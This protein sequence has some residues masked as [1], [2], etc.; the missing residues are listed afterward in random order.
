MPLRLN[1]VEIKDLRVNGVTVDTMMLNGVVVYEGYRS[2]FDNFGTTWY[3][4]PPGWQSVGTNPV[5]GIPKTG[6]NNGYCVRMINN[7]VIRRTISVSGVTLLKVR[8][9]MGRGRVV[10]RLGGVV[11]MDV[12]GSWSGPPG[13][14]E[15][16]VPITGFSG[17]QVISITGGTPS[18]GS[19]VC[20]ID[21]I[22][23]T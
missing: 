7:S 3:T 15:Y 20:Y 4:A 18:G 21:E 17:S 10:I 2:F 12:V 1:G 23:L 16:S 14:Q 8:A 5:S 22:S 6:A 11:V 9:D 13:F 19:M